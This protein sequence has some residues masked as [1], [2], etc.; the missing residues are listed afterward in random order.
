MR[1]NGTSRT[2][3]RR[4]FRPCRKGSA[5]LLVGLVANSARALNP[6]RPAQLD[7]SESP[8]PL[9]HHA[10]AHTFRHTWGWGSHPTIQ[11][12][13]LCFALR[14]THRATTRSPLV[15]ALHNIPHQYHSTPLTFPLFSYSYTLL[16]IAQSAILNPFNT[17][18]TLYRKHPGGG[19]VS[20][21]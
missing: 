4:S 11:N 1:R 8:Q 21:G 5:F 9:F 17:F 20:F 14:Q 15:A 18:H 6:A 16:C 7:T 12:L 19:E 10:L 2:A 13:I 3:Q